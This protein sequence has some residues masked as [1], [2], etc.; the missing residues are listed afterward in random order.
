MPT[1]DYL[2]ESCGHRFEH[3]QGI[4]AAPLEHCP[5]CGGKLRRLI[6]A[7]AGFLT[8]GGTSSSGWERL[9][10]CGHDAPCCG[11]AQPCDSPGCE[12]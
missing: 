12:R 1:Y 5:S 7:G 10:R 11:R 6:G 2:C 3:F 8:K 4:N 9:S